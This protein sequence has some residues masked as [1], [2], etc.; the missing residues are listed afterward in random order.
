[1]MEQR[2]KQQRRRLIRRVT[3]ILLGVWMAVSAAYGFFCLRGEKIDAQNRTL[4]DLSY[5]NQLLSLNSGTIDKPEYVYLTSSNLISFM[6]MLDDPGDS[7]AEDNQCVLIDPETG[8]TLAD[9][10]GRIVVQYA[11]RGD[12][13][14]Y[15]DDYGFLEYSDVRGA[16]N[17]AQ[18]AGITVWLDKKPP[19]GGSYELVCT[20]FY[21]QRDRLVPMEV[22]VMTVAD[23]EGRFDSAVP[24]ETFALDVQPPP[25][26]YVYRNGSSRVNIIPRDFLLREDYHKDLI[27]ALDENQR[28]KNVDAVRVGAAEYLFY[29]SDYFYL[30]AQ[31]FNEEKGYYERTSRPFLLRYASRV[32][33]L[34]NCRVGLTAGVLLSFAFF[35]MVGGFLCVMIW[36]TVRMQIVQEQKRR[37]ITNALAHDIKTPLFVISGTA[38]CMQENLDADE[39]ARSLAAIIE[40]TERIDTLVRQ[41]LDLSRLDSAY[42]TLNP[43][44]FDLAELVQE[45]ADDFSVLPEGRTLTLTHSGDSRISA[46]R[47][48]L[49]AALHNLTDNAVKYSPPGSGIQADVTDRTLRISNPSRPFTRAELK[50]L[51]QPYVRGDASRQKKGN[52]LGL[53]I[54]KSILDL[55][56]AK[57][58]LHM[59][60]ERLVF[61][62]SFPKGTEDEA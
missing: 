55:H 50:R 51:W 30:N 1:M 52:G 6:E 41:M 54:V 37:D 42:A 33:L 47:S 7:R 2:L 40:Q 15:P 16:L 34:R 56:G 24:V 8:K 28:K 44:S 48:L 10:A 3:W 19:E 45:V 43:S 59:E 25:D 29:A 17:D 60:D 62:A 58:D 53:S 36:H 5:A 11:F 31:V 18:Y 20:R 35:W 23:R 46:D 9:T 32:D 38:Y 13:G 27:S 22:T 61:C 49:R 21:A 4:A 57:Y 26:A 12:K 14:D 39:R